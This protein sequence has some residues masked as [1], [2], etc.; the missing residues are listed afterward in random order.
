MKSSGRV[1][2]AALVGLAAV[3]ATI[4]PARAAYTPV[5]IKSCTVVKPRPL[6]HNANGT[7]IVYVIMGHRTASSITF[8]VGYR[9]ATMHYLR[10]VT[11]AGSFSPGV[12][13]DHTLPLYNDVT[14]AGAPTTTCF[15]VEVKWA[16][17][18]V[19][20]APTKP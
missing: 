9:N 13:I 17:G 10:R 14:Y 2:V 5:V 20:M 11:D 12:T 6:S 1:F 18:S 8:A 3:G 19:W 7:H 16:G 15:P 4:G